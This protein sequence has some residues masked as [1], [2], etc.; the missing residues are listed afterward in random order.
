LNISNKIAWAVTD[1]SQGMI[2]Q[3]NGL[4]QLLCSN[5][6]NYKTDLIFPWSKLQPG[7]LPVFKWIFK[8]KI[9]FLNKP[10]ILI[11]CG[12]KSVYFSLLLKK[13]FKKEIITI[14]IQDPKIN[15]ERFNYV[16][17]PKHDEL[18]GSNIIQSLGAIHQ[19]T[20]ETIENYNKDIGIKY[21]NNLV[22]IMLGGQNKHYKF[23]K[24]IV[25]ELI[26]KIKRLKN[27]FPNCI[28]LVIG[29]RRT[30]ETSIDLL[31]NKLNN[32]AYVWDKKTKNPYLFALKNSKFF[33]VTSDSTSMI[34]E[35]AFTGRPVYV[36]HL[37]F[38]RISKRISHF[39]SEFIK[40]NITR[41]FKDNL[42]V[43]QYKPF[44]EAERIAGILKL[45][46]LNN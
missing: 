29:S 45:R 39:H 2:S 7:Y 25:T 3:V 35:C 43:W 38:K 6:K 40:K 15:P 14:H 8:H 19:F 36:Y 34:S 1:G 26:E 30:D 4:A 9:N 18:E 22:S 11:T 37:P 10:D 20:K 17:A 23:S 44:D 28:F 32:T 12:R 31:K 27:K 42:E 16:I 21:S 46:I 5:V 41:N 33:I 24:K 13:I